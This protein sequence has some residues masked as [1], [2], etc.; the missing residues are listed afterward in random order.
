MILRVGSDP[1]SPIP[2][3]SDLVANKCEF[4]QKEEPCDH[5]L[6][7]LYT[8]ECARV[9]LK[10]GHL[11]MQKEEHRKRCSLWFQQLRC[12]CWSGG[13]GELMILF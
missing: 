3:T 8:C 6:V 7:S 2:H 9:V 12:L 5:V 11:E 13:T 1:F 4:L 10:G